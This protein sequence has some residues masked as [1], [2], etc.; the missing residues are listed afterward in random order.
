VAKSFKCLIGHHAWQTSP[1]TTNPT[2]TL[3]CRRC[4]AN[5]QHSTSSANWAGSPR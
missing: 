2:V 5:R 3:E 1:F 4:G